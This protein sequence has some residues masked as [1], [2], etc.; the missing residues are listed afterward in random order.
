MHNHVLADTGLTPAVP[1]ANLPC[2][3]QSEDSDYDS[4]WTATSYRTGS[5][6]RKISRAAA[7]K[8]AATGLTRLSLR[9]ACRRVCLCHRVQPPQPPP[10][11]IMVALSQNESAPHYTNGSPAAVLL[12]QAPTGGT[13]T[14]CSPRRR[15]SLWRR[16]GA[17]GRLWWRRGRVAHFILTL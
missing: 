8:L 1:P 10:H 4:I 12:Q 14:C 13:C 9:P 3:D 17:T 2:S 16:S 6:S 7:K 11:P 5:F 15:R